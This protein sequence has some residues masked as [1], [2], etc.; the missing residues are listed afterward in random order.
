MAHL[1]TYDMALHRG[2]SELAAGLVAALAES[3]G[4]NRI[5][6]EE[7]NPLWKGGQRWLNF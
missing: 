1:P 3:T 4:Q 5:R 7:V 6:E 2:S